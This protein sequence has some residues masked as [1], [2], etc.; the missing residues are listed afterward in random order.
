MKFVRIDENGDPIP[1]SE[2][3]KNKFKELWENLNK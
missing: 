3:V 2:R 1:V